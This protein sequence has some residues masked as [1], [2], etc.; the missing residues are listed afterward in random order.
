M[1][2][3][4]QIDILRRRRKAMRTVQLTEHRISTAA[5]N[6]QH[7]CIS[8]YSSEGHR[9]GQLR[10]P[11]T[12]CVGLSQNLKNIKIVKQIT[13]V[14][15]ASLDRLSKIVKKKFWNFWVFLRIFAALVTFFRSF[16]K[17]AISLIVQFS[18]TEIS[19]Y[20]IGTKRSIFLH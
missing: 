19:N 13:H 9:A 8:T 6:Q 20:N 7:L 14:L 12:H 5:N 17:V 11:P 1:K 4:N 2:V 15:I 16:G 3:S 10:W 18:R